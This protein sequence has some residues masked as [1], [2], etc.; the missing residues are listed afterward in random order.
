MVL[1]QPVAGLGDSI[2][3][4]RP[5]SGTLAA[6]PEGQQAGVLMLMIADG[7]R[8]HNAYLNLDDRRRF[9]AARQGGW[10]EAGTV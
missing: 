9:F 8:S 1:L 4:V 10:G 2:S 6:A 7:S 5:P 3:T